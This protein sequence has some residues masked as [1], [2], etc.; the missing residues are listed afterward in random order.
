MPGLAELSSPGFVS[1]SAALA[2]STYYAL[3]HGLRLMPQQ[4]AAGLVVTAL[5]SA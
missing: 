2:A 4:A 5:V 3:A 1:R